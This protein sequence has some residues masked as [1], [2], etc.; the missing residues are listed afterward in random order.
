[1]SKDARLTPRCIVVRRN[2]RIPTSSAETWLDIPGNVAQPR[3]AELPSQAGAQGG[4]IQAPGD[5]WGSPQETSER[6]EV[7]EGR[8]I[9]YALSNTRTVLPARD[10]GPPTNEE[11]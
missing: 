7:A 5:L 1:M 9:W 6:W 3:V 8:L 4:N 10:S 11:D 2:G